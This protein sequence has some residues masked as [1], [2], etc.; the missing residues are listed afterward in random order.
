MK[1]R[2]LVLL[3][4][5][6]VAVG[7]AHASSAR[8]WVVQG[9]EAFSAGTLDGLAILASGEVVLA[10]DVETRFEGGNPRIWAAARAESEVYV[11]VGET[12]EVLRIAAGAPAEA[13]FTAPSGTV[14]ALVLAPDRRLFVGVTHPARIYVVESDGSVGEEPW[15]ALDADYIWDL[16]FGANGELWVATGEAGALWRVDSTGAAK[17]IYTSPDAH[18]RTIARGS[19]GTIYAGTSGSGHVVRVD[20]DQVSVVLDSAFVEITGLAV[21]GSDLWVAGNAAEPAADSAGNGGATNGVGA[22]KSGVYRMAATGVVD[23]LWQTTDFGIHSMAVVGGRIIAGTGTDGRL[24]HVD[25]HGALGLVADLPSE[26]IVAILPGAND[27]YAVGSNGAA[28]YRVGTELRPTGSLTSAVRDAGTV[29]SWG[30]LRFAASA[31]T[32]EAVQIYVRT[33]NTGAPDDTWSSWSGPYSASGATVRVPTG[34]FAQLRADLHA[35]A[36]APRL[37]RLELVYVPSNSRPQITELRVHPGGVVYRQTASFEDGLPFA[38]VPEVVAAALREQEQGAGAGASAGATSSFRGRPLFIPGQRTVTWAA[39]DPDGDALVQ[40]LF[41]RAAGADRWKR[42]VGPV[43]GDTYVLD[44]ARVPDGRYEM[45]LAVTDEVD[46]APDVALG[47]VRATE[48][49]VVDNTPPQIDDLSAA[50]GLAGTARVTGTATDLTS[51]VLRLRYS[52]NG[53]SW[54]TVLPADGAADSASEEFEFDVTVG[55]DGESTIVVQVTDGALNRGAGQV[56]VSR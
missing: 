15:L 28:V 7:V 42:L 5:M 45:R 11:A 44:T 22:A 21:S 43:L 14:Q 24:L 49:F 19:D 56:I 46:N 53:G 50:P 37:R 35:A 41:Y 3:A 47:A 52:V 6:L 33:G 36:E 51:I 38:Q 12:G 8:T 26:Q 54:H 34:R 32:P 17:A 4:S 55:Q 23:L 9:H 13:Y 31:Q 10:P 18:V 16:E 25:E 29:A 39:S 48:A 40:T 27:V 30:E 20:G 2:K 1:R